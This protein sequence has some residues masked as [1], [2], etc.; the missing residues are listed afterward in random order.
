M[1]WICGMMLVMLPTEKPKPDDSAPAAALPAAARV[2]VVGGGIMGCSLAYH[3]AELGWTDIVLLEKGELTSGSTWHAAGQITYAISNYTLGKCVKYNLDFYD[4]LEKQT[5]Q[6]VTFHRCGSLRV[7]YT[8]DEMDWLRQCASMIA[9]LELPFELVAPARIA[10]LHPFY[11]TDG[12]IGGLHTP[13]DGHLDPAGATFALAKGARQM[14]ATIVRRCRATNITQQPNGEWVVTTPLGD[15][16]CEHVVN[17]GGMYARQLALQNDYNLPTTS[18]THHYLVTETIPEFAALERE[19]PV[20][21]DDS[22]VSG[23]LRME[24]KS[25]LVGIYEKQ[26]S[27]SVWDDEVPWDAENV[28]FDPHW[29]RIEQWVERAMQRIPILASVG[30]KRVVHGAISHPPDGNPLV[31]PAPKLQ[32]YWCCSGCQIGIGWGPALGRELA[33]W[34]AHDAADYNMRELD[35]RRFGDYAD[36]PYQIAKAREDYQTRHDIPYPHIN[37]W[38]ARPLAAA[39]NGLYDRLQ[40]QRA[41]FEE[42]YGFERPRWFAPEGV[43]AEDIYSHRRDAR[44]HKIVGDE[45]LATQKH[46]G[47]MDISAFAKV[48]VSGAGAAAFLDALVPNRLPS[49]GRIALAYFLARNGRMELEATI[50]RLRED[51]F[52]IVTAAFLER[53]LLDILAFA[54]GGRADITITNHSRSWLALTIDGPKSPALLADAADGV[55][56]DI[57]AFPWLAAQQINIGGHALWA[58]RLSYVGECGWELHGEADAV[59]A[60][61]DALTA[62]G[63]AHSLAHYGIFAMNSMRMEKAF[64]G[65]GELTNE[66]NL[67]EAGVLAFVRGGKTG[68]AGYRADL[69]DAQMSWVCV[70]LQVED[71]DSDDGNGG[72]AVFANGANGANGK[73]IGVVSSI[74][75]GHRVGKL[76]A[77]AYVH[78]D[79]A[80]AGQSVQIAIMNNWREAKVLT[81][82]VYDPTNALPRCTA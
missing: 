31:G 16:R 37:R 51:C 80:A 35:P 32:N 27:N 15:V 5:G 44:L 9:G 48:E 61:Y 79:Y 69:A 21:R 76:L 46:V 3:L 11:N 30:V 64:K 55:A 20:V 12:I 26:D 82:A 36:K 59:I 71:N 40:K 65:A 1:Q 18:M 77:F 72:E 23:Y 13:I 63:S 58:M 39:Q 42:I 8:E 67:K 52:Y 17:A 56:T 53:R 2:V 28:L 10:E 14:G 49:A 68:Y 81:Q 45:C 75:Y 7:A 73:R 70:Y 4:R 24:Q 41:V 25:G 57:T 34:I 19:L 78:P 50:T 33:R 74:A 38:A 6:S 62:A 29:E 54:A 60:A 47:I 43:P 22:Q 66:V